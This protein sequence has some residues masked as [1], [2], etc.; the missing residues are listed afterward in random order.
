VG[1][2]HR[3]GRYVKQIKDSKRPTQPPSTN[4]APT[5]NFSMLHIDITEKR[6]WEAN[7][8]EAIGQL[9]AP[10]PRLASKRIN[11]APIAIAMEYF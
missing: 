9:E 8:S 3:F 4:L 5:I 7:R 1:K 10:A 11:I 6:A 2:F